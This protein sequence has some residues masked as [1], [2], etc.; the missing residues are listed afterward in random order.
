M[1]VEKFYHHKN[2]MFEVKYVC[3]KCKLGYT[4]KNDKTM[5]LQCPNNC[6]HCSLIYKKNGANYTDYL[7]NPYLKHYVNSLSSDN[8]NI[9]CNCKMSE[10]FN[11]N[12]RMCVKCH[13][14]NC[15][16]CANYRYGRK[17]YI[18]C[19]LCSI[20]AF[21][22]GITCQKTCKI[23]FYRKDNKTCEK[24][25]GNCLNCALENFGYYKKLYCLSCP[26]GSQISIEGKGCINCTEKLHG[27]CQECFYER[28]G[29]NITYFHNDL[30]IY[31]RNDKYAK[32]KCSDKINRNCG[33][34][35]SFYLGNF[36]C[37]Q[38]HK[39][40]ANC[41]IFPTKVGYKSHCFQCNLNHT[42]RILK[43]IVSTP[44][45]YSTAAS[46]NNYDEHRNKHDE[47]EKDEYEKEEKDEN[48]L[49]YGCVKDCPKNSFYSEKNNTCIKCP[50]NCEMCQTEMKCLKCQPGTYHSQDKRSCIS[51]SNKNFGEFCGSCGLSPIYD[52]HISYN[53][54]RKLHC[55][56]VECPKFYYK[57]GFSCKKCP[58]NC[59]NCD[60]LNG[61]RRCFG[62][63]KINY[64]KINNSCINLKDMN[65][66]EKSALCG[67]GYTLNSYSQ[68]KKC[69]YQC[70]KCFYNE[71]GRLKCSQCNSKFTVD[72]K[73]SFCRYCK[74]N[75]T[76]HK[77]I[78]IDADKQ[79]LNITNEIL[80][81]KNY[82][83]PNGPGLKYMCQRKC[84]KTFEYNRE[85][86]KKIKLII[87]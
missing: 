63:C 65:N 61:A 79:N 22:S 41:K 68:C 18:G 67:P 76:C 75:D 69:P 9:T 53:A 54:K 57:S 28:N 6:K 59:E 4:Q 5:C 78:I 21:K 80:T 34:D 38:C 35:K 66:K 47:H 81:K 10:F 71:Y 62:G 56:D 32:L 50:M 2:K 17:E 74:T 51:C 37:V 19:K 3:N 26:K 7:M 29:H 42:F 48:G 25:P 24:C 44:T 40:C 84:R 12:K 30:M 20:G 64:H 87:L 77:C 8:F 39:N 14:E 85:K 31:R 1:S 27:N 55:F 86:G 23:G 16:M 36:K 43:K 70:N 49:A 33:K 72:L 46:K 11:N 82:Y 83:Y 13:L 73:G 60:L 58:N 45:K 52:N 15:E